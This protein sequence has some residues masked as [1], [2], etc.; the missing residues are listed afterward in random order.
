MSVPFILA[1]KMC[2]LVDSILLFQ[3]Q[4]FCDVFFSLSRYTPLLFC[5]RAFSTG[6]SVSMFMFVIIRALI[7]SSESIVCIC[8]S[9]CF[10]LECSEKGNRLLSDSQRFYN[11]CYEA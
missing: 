11:G 5:V 1:G 4:F 10:Y 7:F 3:R 6:I 9:I 2:V 8:M